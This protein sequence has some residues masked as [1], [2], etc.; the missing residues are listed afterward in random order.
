MAFNTQEQEIIK[1]GA[2]NG[3]SRAE[4]EQAI[5][6]Y[7]AGI[8]PKKKVETPLQPQEP[9]LGSKLADRAKTA[10]KEALNIATLGASTLSSQDVQEARQDPAQAGLVTL[11][12]FNRAFQAPAEIAKAAGGA[13][14][15]VVGAGLKATGVDKAI[16]DTVAP[17]VKPV[18]QSEGARLLA[19]NFNKLPQQTQDYLKTLP[20]I[21]NLIG[22]DVIPAIATKAALKS[23]LNTTA[24]D[25]IKGSSGNLTQ[26]AVDF[27][28]ADPSDKVATILKRS[29]PEEL[30]NYLAIAEKSAA[31]GEA[32]SVFE[33]VGDKMFDATKE[34]KTKLDGI[35]AAKSDVIAKNGAIDFSKQTAPFVSNLENI[36]NSFTKIDEANA[37]IV[38][39]F[40]ADAKNVRTAQQADAF[41]DKAQDALYTG[42]R[43]MTLPKGSSL[44]KKLQRALGEYN[45]ALKAVLPEE[46]SALN[47]QYADLVGTLEVLNRGLGEVVEG[48]A[49][50]GAGLVKQYF[51][52]AASRTKELFE[53]IKKETDGRIDLA[54][55]ATLAKFAGQ[56]Y[57]DA[58]VESLLGGIKDIPTTPGAIVGKVI[59]K[60]GGKQVTEALRRSTVQKAKSS[61]LP[62][63]SKSTK[64]QTTVSPESKVV[65]ST[66]STPKPQSSK[67]IRGM[68]NF[69]EW[70]PKNEG[71]T[72]KKANGDSVVF[73]G[74][75]EMIDGELKYE[76]KDADGSDYVSAKTLERIA[77]EQP[78]IDTTIADNKKSLDA[79]NKEKAAATNREQQAK[80]K[81]AER[82]AQSMELGDFTESMTPMQKAKV[83][84]ALD[85]NIRLSTGEVVTKREYIKRRIEG[86]YEVSDTG[87]LRE[88]GKDAGY[89]LNKTEADY[90]RF[91]S[92]KK[93]VSSLEQEAKG[94]TLYEFIKG[95][96]T[97]VYH[98]TNAKFNM[99]D[100]RPV[101]GTSGTGLNFV[102]SKEHAKNYGSNVMEGYVS[103]KNPLDITSG[104]STKDAQKLN[105]VFE[106]VTF[107]KG[108][109]SEGI[110]QLINSLNLDANEIVSR[111]KK[112]GYDGFLRKGTNGSKLEVSVPLEANQV[113]TKKQLEA[114]WNKAN[115]K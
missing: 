74:K 97:P 30:D 81:A 21:A 11:Q 35:G 96:G 49:I 83:A 91:L 111:M 39:K 78:T 37:P 42:D 40:I 94:K 77:D 68:I 112:A 86:G 43:T 73:T 64:A 59:E 54:K 62:A 17:V 104:I 10:G 5:S 55:D 9:S 28:S 16:S 29:T 75:T 105:E 63:E 66:N 50:R 36:L 106:G 70:I 114:I 67:G 18:V 76:L 25:A 32:K 108:D 69:S 20:D 87:I 2:S 6:N 27:I 38:Q 82:K 7:R 92:K 4:V 61:T 107:S 24:F 12:A 13:I 103:M 100:F 58:N 47:K 26:K 60:V 89:A 93:V 14:G 102:N 22:L 19:Q 85:K 44:E 101:S 79:Y 98:G 113:K 3:K 33:A 15:D 110:T 115:G 88:K 99:E 72:L 95:Q 109:T 90:A 1:F 57:D 46:Y 31:S 52:P 65:P 45:T 41:I 8:I 48:T 56:L 23:P 71:K 84:A 34:L 80:E 51:S 53:F